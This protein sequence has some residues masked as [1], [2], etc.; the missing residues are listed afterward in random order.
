MFYADD[1]PLLLTAKSI[2]NLVRTVYLILILITLK[3]NIDKSL[4]K[5]TVM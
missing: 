2:I 5:V 3:I 1:T 4:P